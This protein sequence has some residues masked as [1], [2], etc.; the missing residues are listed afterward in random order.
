MIIKFSGKYKQV[1]ALEVIKSLFSQLYGGRTFFLIALLLFLW[2]H[3]L[4][5]V[6]FWNTFRANY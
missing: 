1:L 4:V 5:E 3:N 2:N 6:I